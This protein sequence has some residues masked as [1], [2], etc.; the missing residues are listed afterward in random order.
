MIVDLISGLSIPDEW[1]RLL[2]QLQEQDPTAVIAGGAIRDM[3]CLKKPVKDL[4][5]FVKVYAEFR[6][7]RNAP[8]ERDYQ[9]A[10]EFIDGVLYY[11]SALPLPINVVI[12]KGYESTYQ[13]LETFDFGLCQIAFDGVRIIKTWAFD[14]DLRR[15]EMTMRLGARQHHRRETS[16]AR[17]QRWQEKYPEFT[18]AEDHEPAIKEDIGDTF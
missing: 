17:F 14:W 8:P 16:L 13:L 10:N 11:P 3:Y 4:D 7:F 9:G 5:F 1:V 6:Q 2:K 12:G 15:Y 18:L